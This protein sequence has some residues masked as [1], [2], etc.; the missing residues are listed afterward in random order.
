MKH[1]L[2]KSHLVMLLGLSAG[3]AQAQDSGLNFGDM[4]YKHTINCKLGVDAS[5]Y[6]MFPN[7]DCSVLFMG[8]PGIEKPHHIVTL[9]GTISLCSGLKDNSDSVNLLSAQW[10]IIEAKKLKA[11][12][13]D[14]LSQYAKLKKLSEN[15]FTD[16]ANARQEYE[17]YASVPG[18][19]VQSLFDNRA[20]PEDV[21]EFY[22]KNILEYKNN[23]NA[24]EVS[25]LVPENS[26][27][28]FV[29]FRTDGA[30]DKTRSV[31][32]T[33]I[34]GLEVLVQ[35]SGNQ[36]NVAHVKA[37]DSVSGLTEFA[38]ATTCDM[39]HLEGE[40]W[41]LNKEPLRNVMSVNRKY[42]IPMKVGYAIK[43]HLNS[44]VASRVM[45]Q[46]IS[47]STDHNL[48]KAQ[49]Y[50]NIMKIKGKEDFDVVINTDIPLEK[51]QMDELD[52]DIRQRLLDRFLLYYEQR[53]DLANLRPVASE[54]AAGGMV[55]VNHVGTQCWKKSK[56]FSSK[57]GC[58][59]YVYTVQEWRDGQTITQ[60]E[61]HL[62][63]NLVLTETKAIND[64]VLIPFTTAFFDEEI[65]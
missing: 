62:D 21:M 50:E 59:D 43:A 65:K 45:A 14:D 54:P 53:G 34:P 12:N 24:P 29:L 32:S 42:E 51:E 16:I 6:E 11:L 1:Y 31:L 20:K 49:L 46:L 18:S 30:S 61:D 48:S 28:S 64:V 10:K 56:L 5:G 37:G 33:T 41:I 44:K 3:I 9:D 17:K 7:Q 2:L 57:S 52:I 13:E 36:T 27:Y 55:P 22:K 40:K 39:V 58:S 26:I 19:R 23:P 8:P 47:S 60:I 25:I 15:L 63:L 35:S 38:L 4:P